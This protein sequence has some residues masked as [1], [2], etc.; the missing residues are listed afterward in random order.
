MQTK[1]FEVVRLVCYTKMGFSTEN[2]K[3]MLK[4]EFQSQK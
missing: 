4:N 1:L 3:L 2:T